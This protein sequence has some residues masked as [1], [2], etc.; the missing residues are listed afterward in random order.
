MA[1]RKFDRVQETTSGT[2]T[3]SLTLAGASTR[4]RTFAS[5]LAN[6]DTCYVLIEHSS[7]GEWEVCLATYNAGTISRGTVLAS[8]TGATVSFTAGSKTVSLIAPASKMIVEDNNGDIVV[9]RDMTVGRDL[10]L[11]L[12]R[13][14]YI[15][16]IAALGR[17][18][19][20]TYVYEVAGQLCL[21]LSA[22]RN[23]HDAD[24]HNFRK[25]DHSTPLGDLTSSYF[26]PGVDNAATCGGSSYRWSVVYAATGTINTSGRDAKLYISE[27]SD[28]EKRA[29]ARI[30]AGVRRYKM[31]DAVDAKGEARARWHFGYIA[32][33]VRAAL[34]AEGLD[35]GD[36]GFFCA[37]A[38]TKT[39][40]YR[41]GETELAREVETGEVRL[42]LR[43]SE[44]EAFLRSAG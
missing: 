22:A 28:A 37:D 26:R 32:E 2:G 19:T 18:T 40:A 29:A 13:Y 21:W 9:T 10:M 27:A 5:V 25:A 38:I 24:W 44:L 42:G 35:A 16:G 8:S 31:A 43:Y 20:F 12:D 30:K 4:M 3:G 34:E 41:E 36:Y 11:P 33:D 14:I 23:V 7:A 17:S 6:A 15:N 39:E 1:H